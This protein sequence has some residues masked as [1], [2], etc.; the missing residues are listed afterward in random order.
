MPG[1]PNKKKTLATSNTGYK[2]TLDTN[3]LSIAPPVLP[4]DKIARVFRITRLMEWSQEMNIKLDLNEI[5][6]QYQAKGSL[7]HLCL[8]LVLMC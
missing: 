5:M 3:R 4:K 7:S 2:A 8:E 1:V 6:D